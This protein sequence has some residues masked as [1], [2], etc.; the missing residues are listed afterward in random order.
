[1]R[2]ATVIGNRPQ[3][4][5]HALLSKRLRQE[6]DEVIIHTGQHYDDEMSDSF[7]RE[8]DIP[9]P[10]VKL[11]V[12]SGLPFWQVGEMVREVG[13]WL[14][15]VRPRPDLVLVHGDTHSSLAG[16]LAARLLKTP[17]AHVE[18]GARCDDRSVPEEINRI[19]IDHMSELLFCPT[20]KSGHNITN[21]GIEVDR[22]YF[23]GDV[24]Y[25]TYLHYSSR[26][27]TAVKGYIFVTIHREA[28]TNDVDNLSSIMVAIERL[29]CEKPVVFPTHPRT[30]KMIGASMA[31]QR[32][33]PPMSY[34][35]TLAHIKGAD[36]II[37]DSGGVQRE[38]YFAGVPCIYIG[39]AGWP[40]LFACGASK[41]V[42]ADAEEILETAKM[43]WRPDFNKDRLFGKGDAVEKIARAIKEWEEHKRG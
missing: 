12:G 32:M 29:T 39:T 33:M 14:N 21:E 2:I 35:D 15:A 16:A 8:L 31:P 23:T 30:R 22:V 20:A 38:A 25:D 9:Q 10:D 6:H 3:F 40:E 43:N 18:A 11:G 26:T 36:L 42:R 24:L 5:K 13:S 7:F 17:V 4:I 41:Q 37:T 19:L 27:P 28:N 1:M 34:L